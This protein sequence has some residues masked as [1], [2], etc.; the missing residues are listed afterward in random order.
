MTMRCA[1]R[2]KAQHT[3]SLLPVRI[4]IARR[5]ARQPNRVALGLA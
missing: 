2:Y 3:H 1:D 5:E 4:I